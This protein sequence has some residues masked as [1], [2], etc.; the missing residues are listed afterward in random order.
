VPPFYCP[1][2][3]VI[4]SQ[5]D[6]LA[7]S[8]T[9]WAKRMGICPD[10]RH[11]ARV[12]ASGSAEFAARTAPH[13]STDRLRIYADVVHWAFAFDD[14]RCDGQDL[15]EL[16]SLVARLL[17]MLDGVNDRL[18]GDDPFR[19]ALHDIAL[20]FQD[21]ATT[22]QMRRWVEAHRQWLFGVIQI[23]A[24]SRPDRALDLD[25]YMIARFHDGGG[26]VVTTMMEAMELGP[27]RDVPGDEMD[28]PVV[29]ALT[30]AC[31]TI[32]IW[33]NDRIPATRNS[34][35]AP[36]GA[37]WSMSSRRPPTALLNRLSARP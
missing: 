1:V 9:K 4:Q 29:R 34:V 17:R 35:A 11:H 20:R 33:D 26:P 28:S 2:P 27:G 10:Q 5:F 19:V 7:D 3:P 12:I 15:T 23:N 36:T 21:C 25:E 18:C 30:E 8:S 24:K 16:I 6:E 14:V 22:A 31:W 13:G 37:I 32:A